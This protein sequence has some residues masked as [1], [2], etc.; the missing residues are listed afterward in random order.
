M[1]VLATTV[2]GG[3]LVLAAYAGPGVLA[4]GVVGLAALLA[5]ALLAAGDLPDQIAAGALVV[6]SAVGAVVSV[7][8]SDAGPGGELSFAPVLRAVGPVIVVV[9][10]VVVARPGAREQAVAWLA[11]TAAGVVLAGL[12][13]ASVAIGRQGSLGAELIAIMVAAAV[14]GSAAA[15]A[16]RGQ[17]GW[18]WSVGWVVAGVLAALAAPVGVVERTDRLVLAVAVAVAAG[19]AASAVAGVTPPNRTSAL[20]SAQSALVA[21]VALAVAAPV[22]ATT[23]RVLLT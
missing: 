3:L 21:C 7:L 20:W 18:L 16:P 4:I 22:T 14:V 8:L 13:A 23:V 1:P 11:V 6:V 10:L 2:V 15:V 12:S 17:F 9:L 19:V 5:Y